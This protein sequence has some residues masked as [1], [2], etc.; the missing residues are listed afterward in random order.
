MFSR[1]SALRR[2]AISYFCLELQFWFP[3][4]ILFLTDRG[5]NLTTMVLADA[6][7]RFTMVA[8]EFP[9]GVLGDRIGRRRSYILISFLALL[10]YAGIS[11]I[12]NHFMLF[13]TWIVWGVFWAMASGTTSAYT[14]ELVKMEGL[15]DATVSI[16]G[17]MRAISSVAALLSHLVAGFLF[18]IQPALPFIVNGLFALVAWII[19]FTLPEITEPS[20]EV[21]LPEPQS[22]KRFLAM[23]TK[24]RAFLGGSILL[25]VALV[26][27]WSPRILMQPLFL[28]LGLEPWVVSMVYFFYSLAGVFAGLMASRIRDMLGNKTSIVLGFGFIFVGVLLIAL[29][30]G[31]VVLLFFPLLSFGYYLSQTLLEVTLHHQIDNKNRASFLS[32][33]SF[34]GGAVIIITRPGLGI[35]ADRNDVQFAFLIWA[36]LGIGL[37][38]VFV[39]QVRKL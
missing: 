38:F 14:Y 33:I 24:S 37:L 3:V 20:E 36:A 11:L 7:F 23:L 26:Y 5:F 8:L 4:W 18:T 35:L 12:S 32:A 17:K 22:F 21:P 16:F 2:L 13:A 10:T 28:E 30:N 39:T 25:A 9:M 27:F 29:T 15:D 6:T 34:V 19:S 1:S 31:T